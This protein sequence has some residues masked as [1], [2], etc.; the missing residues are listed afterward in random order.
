MFDLGTGLPVYLLKNSASPF[1]CVLV[2]FLH[3]NELT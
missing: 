1:E 2:H 3:R